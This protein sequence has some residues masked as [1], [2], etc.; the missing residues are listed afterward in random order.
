MNGVGDAKNLANVD[1]V[2][3]LMY[4]R[5]VGKQQGAVQTMVGDDP[6]AGVVCLNLISL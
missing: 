6:L 4:L 2:A 1:I 3:G 5:I